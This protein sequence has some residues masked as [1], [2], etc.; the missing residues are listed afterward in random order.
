M[1]T[2]IPEIRKLD[3]KHIRGLRIGYKIQ[4]K[5]ENNDLFKLANI[6]NLENRRKVHLRNFMFKNKK[7]CI[8]KE[9]NTI[10]TRG[11]SGPSFEVKKP[12]CESYKRNIYYSGAQEWNNLDADV[13]KLEHF[14]Q[15]KR[16]Q[17]SWLINTYS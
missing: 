12:N 6:S 5:I 11:N 8:I 15:F 16:I 14:Y 4:G 7:K 17:K 2:N 10:T 1:S 3:K 13:R 9:E